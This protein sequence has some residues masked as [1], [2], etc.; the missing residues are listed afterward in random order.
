MIGEKKNLDE[1]DIGN[2][3]GLSNITEYYDSRDS[4]N[5]PYYYCALEDCYDEQGKARQIYKHLNSYS[6]KQSWLKHSHQLYFTTRPQIDDWFQNN[7]VQPETYSSFENSSLRNRCKK[8]L[9]RKEDLILGKVM[10]HQNA[11]SPKKPVKVSQSNTNVTNVNKHVTDTTKDITNT[12]EGVSITTKDVNNPA[13]EITQSGGLLERR[14][15]EQ[16]NE[17]ISSMQDS[18]AALSS[19]NQ[20]SIP[21]Q[22]PEDMITR[23]EGFEPTAG[24]INPTDQ[25]TTFEM[26]VSQESDNTLS[27]SANRLS[28]ADYRRK[29]TDATTSNNENPSQNMPQKV[30]TTFS[31]IK[32]ENTEVKM[33]EKNVKNEGARD[34][35]NFKPQEKED[36]DDQEKEPPEVQY[37][38]IVRNA[39]NDYLYLEK[40]MK[41]LKH[42][43]EP[44]MH[45]KEEFIVICKYLST[46]LREQIR[47]SWTAENTPWNTEA[48]PELSEVEILAYPIHFEIDKYFECDPHY[49]DICSKRRK[50]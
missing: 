8:S 44:L 24:Y 6:H 20:E 11:S 29:R 49:K 32:K 22:Y 37:K 12:I 42:G 3:V 17:G 16:H 33:E 38:T 7:A 34:L 25:Q 14:S 13:K 15:L 40:Y 50:R 28:L 19:T 31:W 45:N 39:V 35:L 18:N 30:T 43:E 41:E 47:D 27:M 21:L 48:T 46:F 36:T 2:L 10:A 26:A 9:M 4:T 1:Y 5:T 23:A